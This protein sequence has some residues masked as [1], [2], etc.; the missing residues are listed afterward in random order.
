ML[1]SKPASIH[2]C[3]PRFETSDCESIDPWSHPVLRPR[4]MYGDA[5]KSSEI[6][7]RFASTLLTLGNLGSVLI[8]EKRY[9]EAEQVLREALAGLRRV[10]GPSH[11]VTATAAHNLAR[12]LAWGGK[13]D[14]AFVY[15]RAFTESVDSVD[16]IQKVEK[17]D[18][19]QSVHEDPRFNALLAAARQR[20]AAAQKQPV[21]RPDRASIIPPRDSSEHHTLNFAGALTSPP[22]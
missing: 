8:E 3:A 7:R 22:S 13:R 17:D 20:I 6:P 2:V 4:L 15:L 18:S 12:V 14:E 11:E 1:A 19:L 10:L 5:D 21:T 16:D 9:S